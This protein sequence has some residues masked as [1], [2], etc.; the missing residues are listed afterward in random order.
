MRMASV[1]EMLY[2]RPHFFLETG[3]AN[4]MAELGFGTTASRIADLEKAMR[5]GALSQAGFLGKDERLLD[6]MATD[7]EVGGGALWLTHQELARPFL[8]HRFRSSLPGLASLSRPDSQDCS[9][10]R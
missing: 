10:L 7:N 4:R 5:P 1:Q 2:L 3:R 9:N 6:V 8:L